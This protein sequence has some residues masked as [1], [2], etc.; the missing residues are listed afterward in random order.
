MRQQSRHLPAFI[1]LE[2]LTSPC[3]GGALQSHLN[4]RLPGLNADSGAVYRTLL[5]ME[6][7]GEVESR[8]D[9]SQPGPAKRIY[10]ITLAGEQRLRDWE[11]EIVRRRLILDH[12]LHE[13]QRLSVVRQSIGFE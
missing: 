13:Y 6:Q 10:S 3:H 2:L 4:L 11:R 12:F 8:W 1:L 7:E 5:K 9:T